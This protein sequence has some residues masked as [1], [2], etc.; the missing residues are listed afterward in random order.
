MR[1]MQFGQLVITSK[2]RQ[3]ISTQQLI[4]YPTNPRE[5]V[6]QHENQRKEK[7]EEEER[8]DGGKLVVP[9]TSHQH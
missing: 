3:T 8:I 7:E 9:A 1:N 2:N 6:K 5:K 4:I